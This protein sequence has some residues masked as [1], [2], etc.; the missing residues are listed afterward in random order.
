MDIIETLRLHKL[1]LDGNKDG[2]CADLQGASLGGANL[3]YANL[4]GANLRGADLQG[5]N[6][7]YA[8]LSKAD[9]GGADLSGANLRGANLRGAD[10]YYANLRGADLSGADLSGTDLRGT[11]LRGARLHGAD[12]REANLYGANLH[13]A[14]L[15]GTCLDPRNI[16][17]ITENKLRSHGFEIDADGMAIGYRTKK[18]VVCGTTDYR[19]GR[20][21]APWFSTCGK[22][23]CHPGIYVG[24]HEYIQNMYNSEG[25]VCVKFWPSSCV[26]AGNK[27]RCKEIFVVDE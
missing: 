26:K 17:N 21:V 19:I 5:A 18:S 20:Y 25:I 7:R 23:E 14:N 1:W 10:L 24:T 2:M 8:N 16:G 27:F 13:G 22:T 15:R 4:Y 11:N 3:R 9:M 6:L 12:L